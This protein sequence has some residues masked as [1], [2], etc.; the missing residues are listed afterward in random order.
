MRAIVKG[1]APAELI[2]YRAV[3]GAVYDGGDFTPVKHATQESGHVH[4]P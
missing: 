3:P 1:A 2:R 4:A